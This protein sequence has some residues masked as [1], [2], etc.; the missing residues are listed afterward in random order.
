MTPQTIAVVLVA[1]GLAL[2]GWAPIATT[3]LAPA[4]IQETHR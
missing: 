2:T 1:A 4:S 3:A